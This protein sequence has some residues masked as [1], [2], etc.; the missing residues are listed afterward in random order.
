MAETYKRAPQEDKNTIDLSFVDVVGL[1]SSP[2]CAASR[3]LGL[4]RTWKRGIMI[5]LQVIR[6]SSLV[7]RDGSTEGIALTGYLWRRVRIKLVM[8][9][10]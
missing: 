2:V 8:D 4:F 1:R 7:A 6:Y 10:A 9:Y 3:L 5:W